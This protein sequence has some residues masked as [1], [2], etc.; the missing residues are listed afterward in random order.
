MRF[1]AWVLVPLLGCWC[2]RRAPVPDVWRA[3]LK[4]G[5]WFGAAA[6]CAAHKSLGPLATKLTEISLG[7][8]RVLAGNVGFRP[9]SFGLRNDCSP[10][11]VR[12]ALGFSLSGQHGRRR[13]PPPLPRPFPSSLWPLRR[14]ACWLGRFTV[15]GHC[16]LPTHLARSRWDTKHCRHSHSHE[17]C[18]RDLCMC[19]FVFLE[20][21][22]TAPRVPGWNSA[23]GRCE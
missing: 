3:L 6:R 13:L 5:R 1:G 10:V 11:Q 23:L 14:Q 15:W 9:R 22:R 12:G 7:A 17:I 20:R 16:D 4:L 21:A 8:P 19:F 2:R 18:R